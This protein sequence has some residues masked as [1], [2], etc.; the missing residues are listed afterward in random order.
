[1][2]SKKHSVAPEVCLYLCRSTEKRLGRDVNIAHV[3]A[4]INFGKSERAL[5]PCVSMP[6]RTGNATGTVFGLLSYGEK[7]F[8]VKLWG[9]YP[10]LLVFFRFRVS[11]CPIFG[12]VVRYERHIFDRQMPNADAVL[13]MLEIGGEICFAVTGVITDVSFDR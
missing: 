3:T 2:N 12:T 1:M 5:L 4:F 11:G 9:R 13:R 6:F 10:Y 7:C 8:S